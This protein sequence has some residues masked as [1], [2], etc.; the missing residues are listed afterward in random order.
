MLPQP[1]KLGGSRY[2]YGFSIRYP[3]TSSSQTEPSSRNLWWC[4]KCRALELPKMWKKSMCRSGI[5]ANDLGCTLI[6]LSK[7]MVWYNLIWLV[8]TEGGVGG[9]FN[10]ELYF[11]ESNQDLF[12]S[13]LMKDLGRAVIDRGS[14]LLVYATGSF[15]LPR[16]TFSGHNGP[17]QL[18]DF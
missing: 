5:S 18:F 10:S 11:L 7:C 6:W 4:C 9:W 16:W 12:L 8:V 3:E 1:W 15:F 14:K 17:L 2:W 13:P